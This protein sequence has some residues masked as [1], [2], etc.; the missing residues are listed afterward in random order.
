MFYEFRNVGDAEYLRIDTENNMNFPKHIHQSY[1]IIHMTAGEM[2]VTVDQNEYTLVEGDALFV[3]PNQV[4]SLQSEHSDHV[5]FIFSPLLVNSY[6]SV[7]KDKVPVR[8]VFRPSPDVVSALYSLSQQSPV[9]RKKGAL[10]LFCA[11][12]DKTASYVPRSY[13]S[14]QFSEIFAFIEDNYTGECSLED[15][16]REIGMNYSYI[17]RDFKKLAGMCFNEYVNLLRLN[18][19]SYLLKNT[20]MTITECALESGFRSTHTFNRNFKKRYKATPYQYRK[21]FGR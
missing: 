20:K 18:K 11:D 12:F 9:L 10:Y 6:F 7:V 14:A 15:A 2:K 1:E 16:A 19:A 3:F 17:S 4:H 8:P 13:R 5:T 21:A